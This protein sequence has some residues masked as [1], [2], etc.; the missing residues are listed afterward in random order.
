MT[1][2]LTSQVANLKSNLNSQASRCSAAPAVMAGG[3]CVPV[4]WKL[5]LCEELRVEA[6][7]KQKRMPP[8]DKLDIYLVLLGS[9]HST[10]E[11][12]QNVKITPINIVDAWMLCSH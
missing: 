4:L 10:L 1:L 2:P 6:C 12:G 5:L 3:D 11:F 8:S 7:W 9:M